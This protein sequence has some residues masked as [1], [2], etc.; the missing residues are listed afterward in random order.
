MMAP[1]EADF[2]FHLPFLCLVLF[3]NY[4]LILLLLVG[5]YFF[6]SKLL[7]TVHMLEV[8]DVSWCFTLPLVLSLSY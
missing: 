8:V 4:K 7:E 1:P 6:Q 5:G 2:D 3:I